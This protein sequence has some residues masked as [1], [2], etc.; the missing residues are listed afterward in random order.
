[1]TNTFKVNNFALEIYDDEGE[2]CAFYTVRWVDSGISETDKFFMKYENS[3]KF[4]HYLQELAIFLTKKMGSETGALEDF[5]RFETK[6][7]ALPP[8]GI[9]NVDEININY[10]HFPLRLYCLR[11]SDYLVVL[12]NG[13]EKTSRTAQGGKTAMAFYEAN[14]FAARILEA[15]KNKDIY[16]AANQR[17]FKNYDHTEEIIL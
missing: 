8:A 5:F 17:T 13:A 15:L 6:A 7:H 14:I 16:I 10:D 4:K 9:Y 2:K 3:S 12:F 11:I 1:M